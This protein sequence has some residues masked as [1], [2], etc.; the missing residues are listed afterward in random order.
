MWN[1]NIIKN[2]DLMNHIDKYFKEKWYKKYNSILS[3]ADSSY[4]LK[5]S[6]EK[7]IR[8]FLEANV[9]S[10]VYDNGAIFVEFTSQLQKSNASDNNIVFNLTL[11][12]SRN[13]LK[14]ENLNLDD[15]LKYGE[16]EIEK[17]FTNDNFEYYEYN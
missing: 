16:L 8:Y 12:N 17:L 9:F 5:I 15:E 1:N 13:L 7:G 14:I 6:D 11:F 3:S 4:Q 10:R 2:D